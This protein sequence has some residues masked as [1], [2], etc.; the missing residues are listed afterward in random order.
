MRTGYDH[1]VSGS[2]RAW[3]AERDGRMAGIVDRIR[4]RGLHAFSE[5]GR[6]ND[7]IAALWKI[8]RTLYPRYAA[9][10]SPEQ[11]LRQLLKDAID[12]MDSAAERRAAPHL[13]GMVRRRDVNDS[14]NDKYSYSCN[15]PERYYLAANAY[16]NYS[17]QGEPQ[18]HTFRTK[19]RYDRAI[20][21]HVG[22]MIEKLRD[23]GPKERGDEL[24]V[25]AGYVRR[26]ELE[27]ELDVAVRKPRLVVLV[28][29]GGVGKS[30]LAREYVTSKADPDTCIIL[31][32]RSE[33]TLMIGIRD[34][35]GEEGKVLSDTAL[36]FHLRTVLERRDKAPSFIVFDN[37]K[38]WESI[39]SIIPDRPVSNIIVTVRRES[40]D[41][42]MRV[43]YRRIS[44]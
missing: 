44:Y 35:L 16:R 31:D 39:D 28:G 42:K 29:E 41:K 17:E 37:V 13:F 19:A 33:T 4:V 20:V 43:P 26:P 34:S 30:T 9:S 40:T 10:N 32:A 23:R 3:D 7:E 15:L 25:S 12:E 14:R 1:V 38:N 8:G 18:P 21:A 11:V 36:L 27:A 5:Y 6:H 22:K 24:V 2:R